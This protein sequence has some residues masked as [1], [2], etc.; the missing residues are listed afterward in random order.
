ML[1]FYVRD[2]LLHAAKVDGSLGADDPVWQEGDPT[3]S[4]PIRVTGRLSQ[5]GPG[6]FYFSGQM[7]GAAAM[8][9]RRCLTDVEVKVG[10]DLHLLFAEADAGD[11]GEDDD[12][13]VYLIDHRTQEV[14]LRQAVREAW[15]LSIPPFALCRDDCEGICPRCGAD[16][17]AGACGCPPESV[18]DG[19]W[20][21]LRNVRDLSE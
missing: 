2:L 15:V 9:C 6:R 18:T 3:P 21:A 10:D 7:E 17:N 16:L 12:P 8:E 13:D 20:E 14:D 5:A 11:E 19:R 1:S 4:Q